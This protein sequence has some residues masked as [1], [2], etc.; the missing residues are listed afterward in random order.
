MHHRKEEKTKA[1]LILF[2]EVAF[3]KVV[4]AANDLKYLFLT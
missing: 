1:Q 4:E 3:K 2:A